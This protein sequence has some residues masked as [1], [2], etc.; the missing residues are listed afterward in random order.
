MKLLDNGEQSRAEWN[1]DKIIINNKT[2][3]GKKEKWNDLCKLL[4]ITMYIK[5]SL[6]HFS[7]PNKSVNI[8]WSYA[9]SN[10][11]VKYFSQ[12]LI[13]NKFRIN[14]YLKIQSKYQGILHGMHKRYCVCL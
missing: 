1:I 5:I 3:N 12:L 14:Y 10:H 7:R 13:I 9:P 11:R 2:E 8:H 4:E 6:K